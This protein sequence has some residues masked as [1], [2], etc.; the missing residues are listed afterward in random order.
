MTKE[1]EETL[2]VVEEEKKIIDD[3]R[4][5]IDELK[6]KL[7]E[8]AETL[9]NNNETIDLL[10]NNLT[11]AQKFSFRALLSSKQTQHTQ[12]LSTA[13]PTLE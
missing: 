12:I 1:K 3:L 13:A 10:K 2:V 9:K 6:S 8:A 5:N 7:N 11:E 4:S